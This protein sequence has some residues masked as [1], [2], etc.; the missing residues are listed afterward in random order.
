MSPHEFVIHFGSIAELAE[1]LSTELSQGRVFLAGV[2]GPAEGELV[3][4]R[5]VLPDTAA[6]ISA[7]A[8]VLSRRT[9]PV[10]GPGVDAALLDLQDGTLARVEQFITERLEA[11]EPAAEWGDPERPIDVLIVDD[12]PIF[13]QQAA[14]AFRRDGDVVRFARHGFE[15]LAAALQRRP[16][17]ILSDV[18]MPRMDGWQLLRMIRGNPRLTSVPVVFT[19]ALSSERERLRGYQLGVDDFIAK[20]FRPVELRA[21]A[22]RLMHRALRDASEQAFG[23]SI[24]GDLSQ[25]S[26]PSVLSLLEL[27]RRAGRIVIEGPLRGTLW[28]ADGRVLRAEVS[29]DAHVAGAPLE[30]AFALIDARHGEFAFVA[31]TTVVEDELHCSITA[32]LMEHARVSD[33][34]SRDEPHGGG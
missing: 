20:P 16:D 15:A 10:R 7:T 32:L 31:E 14:A 6:A 3:L 11:S 5:L 17:V 4:V 27:E 29:G 25:V 9:C 18:N 30:R 2:E 21:R 24:R 13:Q 1:V 34:A 28:I 22:E 19:T 26:L 8:R 33:E 23:S 12:D